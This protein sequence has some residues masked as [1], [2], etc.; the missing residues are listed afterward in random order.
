MSDI[1]LVKQLQEGHGGWNI[2]MADVLGKEGYVHK[3]RIFILF[4][5]F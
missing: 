1:D 4:I 3:S 5:S 2:R